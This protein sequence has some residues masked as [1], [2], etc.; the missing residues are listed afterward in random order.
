MPIRQIRPHSLLVIIEKLEAKG[1]QYTTHMTMQLCGR[2]FRYAIATDRA[3]HN[4]T[5]DIKG[6]ITP[7][8]EEHFPSITVPTKVGKL[9]QALDNFE[10]QLVVGSALKMAPLVT[11][12]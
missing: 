4:I 6:A 1:I 9:L 10:G 5:P 7:H 12:F 8:K 2:V 11:S 3:D